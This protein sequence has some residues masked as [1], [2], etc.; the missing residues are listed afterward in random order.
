MKLPFS[1]TLAGRLVVL[2]PLRRAHAAD[3]FASL[4]AD[5]SV[6]R[7]LPHG[8][9]PEDVAQMDAVV[10]GHLALQEAMEEIPFAQVSAGTG[11]AVGITKYLSIAVA[12]SG[13]EIGG[14]WLGRAAQRTG[15]NRE[16]K[17]LLLRNAF[18]ELGAIRVQLKTDARNAQSQRA[19][20]ELGAVREGV[21]RKH[22]QCWDGFV[23]DS[24]MFSITR[25]EW[26][27]VK[28]MLESRLVAADG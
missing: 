8:P 21:L 24:V 25:D 2:E 3:L 17:F 4:A 19:I 15:I 9:P 13:L 23:R 7:W 20:A 27:G 11:R 18:E 14:T 22:K 1:C 28:R 16:A 12:D 6:L 5:P 10:A 26:P